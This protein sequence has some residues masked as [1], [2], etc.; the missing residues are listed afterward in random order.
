[1]GLT[2]ASDKEVALGRVA[3]VGQVIRE[4]GPP[5]QRRALQSVFE[6]VEVSPEPGDVVKLVPRPWFRVFSR[7]RPELLGAECAWRGPGAESVPRLAEL[8]A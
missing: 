1:M 5:Q 7:N 2:T 8:I 4:G 3:D 6:R